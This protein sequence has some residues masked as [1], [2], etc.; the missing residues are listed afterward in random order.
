MKKNS[1]FK[2]GR[3]SLNAYDKIKIYFYDSKV[4][5]SQIASII[6]PEYNQVI[7]KLL[8]KKNS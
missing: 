3:I 7:I 2:V 8:D 4:Q 1:N 6:F 5:I